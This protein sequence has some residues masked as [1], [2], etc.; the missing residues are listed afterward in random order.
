IGDDKSP[1]M[2][3]DIGGERTNIVIVAS[4][5]PLM[6]RSVDV[7]GKIF[8]AELAKTLGIETASAE[9]FKLDAEKLEAIA[10]GDSVLAE[11][12][13]AVLRPAL[14][15]IQ[16][17]IDLYSNQSGFGAPKIEKII[18]TGGACLLPGLAV[19]L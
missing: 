11:M 10:P 1:A 17:A 7:G 19:F 3:L 4:G 13:Q 6:S 15:E 2:I 14:N 8:T 18:L 5:L 16:Y 9:E 12:Y